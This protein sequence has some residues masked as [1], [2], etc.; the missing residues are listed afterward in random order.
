MHIKTTLLIGGIAS[1]AIARLTFGQ[2]PSLCFNANTTLGSGAGGNLLAGADRN[3]AV[4]LLALGTSTDDDD[5]TATGSHALASNKGGHANTATGANALLSNTIGISNTANGVAALRANIDGDYNTA[6]GISVLESNTGGGFNT[7]I[8]ASALTSNTGGN[9]NT[10]A[11]LNAL[12][13]NKTGSNNSAYGVNALLNN[14]ASNN[15]ASG[16]FALQNNGGGHDNTAHG[17]QALKGNVGGNNNVAVGSNAGANL[18]TGSNNIVI[19]GGIL[20]VAGEANT[21]RIGKSTQAK[22]LI[23]GIYGKPVASATGVPVRIDSTGKLGTVLSSARYKEAVK[24]MDQASDRIL[25]LKPVTFQYKKDVDPDGTTQFGLI[26]E[27][28]EKV[29]P[30]LIVRDQDGKPSTVRYEA[31]NAMLLNEFLKEHAQVEKQQATIERQQKQIDALTAGLQKVTA[32]LASRERDQ[33]VVSN[34]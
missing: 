6:V 16:F 8:G 19:G 32:R 18:T 12:F 5:N 9:S 31:V 30:D 2:C 11:G 29:A 34:E 26:A 3:T 28:V 27:Q 14:T 10:A 21:T 7:A 4:G 20:G 15:S 23:G 13:F 25:E 17:F 24:P 33:R 22:T 1:M